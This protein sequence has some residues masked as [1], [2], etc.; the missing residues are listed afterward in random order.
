MKQKPPFIIAI[1]GVGG[2]GKNSIMEAFKK[3]PN[4]FTFFVSYTDRPKRDD[5][6]VG[7]SYHFISPAEFSKAIENDEFIEWEKVRGSHRYGRKKVDFENILN[8]GK[9]PVMNIEVLGLEKF[10]K[11]YKT[12]SFFI[13]PPSREEAIARMEKR[14][15]DTKEAI[16]HRADRYDMELRHKDKYDHIVINDNLSRAQEEVLDLVR[17]EIKKIKEKTK[18][19]HTLKTLFLFLLVLSAIGIGFV[20]SFAHEKN[21][22]TQTFLPEPP[23]TIEEKDGGA[24]TES[25]AVATAPAT[26]SEIK[27]QVSASP[28]KQNSAKKNIV[29][30]TKKN[31]D[32]STTTT[33]AT[34]GSATSGDLARASS[35]QT[36]VNTPYDITFRD[37]TGEHADLGQKLKDYVNNQLKW[38]NEISSMKE[39]TLRDAGDSGWSGQYLG[40][41][42]SSADNQDIVSASG[43]IILNSYYYK[44]S[45]LFDDYMKLV[46]AHEY[47]HHYTLYHKW[48]DWDLPAGIRFPDSYYTLRPLPKAGTVTDYSLGWKNCEVEIIAEDYSYIYSGYGLDAM[49]LTYGFPSAGIKSWLDNI[50]S[51]AEKANVT[52]NPPT[53]E[54]TSPAPDAILTGQSSFK[55]N[56]ADDIAVSKVSFYIGEVLIGEDSQSPYEAVINSQSYPNACYLLKA[57]VTD[58]TFTAEKTVSVNFENE[59]VDLEKPAIS[60]TAPLTNPYTLVGDGLNIRIVATDNIAIAKIEFYF[61]NTLQNSWNIANLNLNTSFVNIPAGTY[62]LK[63]KAYDTAGNSNETILTIIKP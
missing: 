29:E 3:Y 25:A 10:K 60:I 8:S 24:P 35:L 53:L 6:V 57:V 61:E 26:A 56:A 51:T 44:N 14:G 43:T 31:T 5:D 45:A 52:N 48:V 47:G 38:R 55:V 42:L 63:F 11:I 54:I 30:G 19:V 62:A 16:Q 18:K 1:S 13:L 59:T 28:P 33:I 41:Y 40:Q 27:K 20:Y 9:F 21:Q 23:S 22:F 49:S 39:I 12:L 17:S 58:G 32:G 7:E 36:T 50:G 15:T 34:S 37:E 46:L 4:R 2:A